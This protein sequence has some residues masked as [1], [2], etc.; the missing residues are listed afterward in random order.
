MM[1][2]KMKIMRWNLGR[3]FKGFILRLRFGACSVGEGLRV[4]GLQ[5]RVF[6]IW[7]SR[8]K[9]LNLVDR[10]GALR[11]TKPKTEWTMGGPSLRMMC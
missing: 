4:S 2:S 7:C 11:A 3:G 10:H 9:A 5:G 1:T 6:K 8:Y